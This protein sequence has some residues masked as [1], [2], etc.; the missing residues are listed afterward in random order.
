M[1][2]PGDWRWPRDSAKISEYVARVDAH[3]PFQTEA[4]RRI[5]EAIQPEYLV[6]EFLPATFAEWEEK[7]HTQR[8]ALGWE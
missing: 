1:N 2:T 3:R 8:H 6:H 4:V 5:V 7:V